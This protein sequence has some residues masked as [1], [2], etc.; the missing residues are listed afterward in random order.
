M[1]SYQ[2]AVSTYCYPDPILD[3]VIT[4]GDERNFTIVVKAYLANYSSSYEDKRYIY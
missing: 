2:K 3:T 4:T 1:E